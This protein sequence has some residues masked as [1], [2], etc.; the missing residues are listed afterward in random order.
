MK[1]EKKESQNSSNI[2]WHSGFYGGIELEFKA[3]KNDLTFDTER[4]LSKEPLKMDMLIIKKNSV[5]EIKNQI[6]IIFRKYNVLEYKSPEDGMSIDDYVKTVAYACLYKGLGETVD[7]IPLDELTITICR[8]EYPRELIRSIENYGGTVEREYPGIYYVSGI[9]SVPSQI[10]VTRELE[11]KEH[12]VLRILSKNAI[13][14]DVIQFI[15]DTDE[16]S[17][18]GDINNVNAVLQVSSK[19]NRALYDKIRRD[20]DMCQALM[21]IM[22]EE[23]KERE[24]AAVAANQRESVMNLMEALNYTAEQ[25]MDVLKIPQEK[26]ESLIANL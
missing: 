8:N 7:A 10:I 11:G 1:E 3:Y 12:A 21:E 14:E 22:S 25:A 18:P 17:T 16:N 24:D 13:E 4:E 6:G 5:V 9:I 2:Y 26:R 15:E 19:A 20:K 23:V